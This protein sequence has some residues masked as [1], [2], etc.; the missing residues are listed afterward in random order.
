MVTADLDC[1]YNA[2]SLAVGAFKGPFGF[3]R[4]L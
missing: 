1:R 3:D 4:N 2:L